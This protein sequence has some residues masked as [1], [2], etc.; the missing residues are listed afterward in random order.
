MASTNVGYSIFFNVEVGSQVLLEDDS[1]QLPLLCRFSPVRRNLHK[2]PVGLLF[3]KGFLK[4]M[5][6]DAFRET[7][8]LKRCLSLAITNKIKYYLVNDVTFAGNIF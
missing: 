4:S 1:I 5:F 8:D 3:V 6:H 2:I 7:D